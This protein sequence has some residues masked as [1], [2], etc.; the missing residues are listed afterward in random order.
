MPTQREA[1]L[2]YQT[3]YASTHGEQRHADA[4]L[5]Y[6]STLIGML[7]VLNL[8]GGI[9]A[10][11]DSKFYAGDAKFV[12]GSLHTYGW[13]FTIIGA[14]QLLVAVGA[15]RRSRLAVWAGVVILSLNAIGQLLAIEA[16]PFWSLAI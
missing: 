4:W 3:E 12:V 11:S 9:A 5:E 14:L 6:A 1:Q 8:I 7:G 13:T 16:R 15:F 10:L 2:R